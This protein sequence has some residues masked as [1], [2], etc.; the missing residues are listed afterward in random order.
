[1]GK[2]PSL[3]RC[4]VNKANF[5]FCALPATH[6]FMTQDGASRKMKRRYCCASCIKDLRKNVR[7]YLRIEAIDP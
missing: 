2:Q 6:V 3:N 4:Q 7:G 1:M 5:N